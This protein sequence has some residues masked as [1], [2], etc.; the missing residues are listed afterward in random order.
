M[1]STRQS[2]PRLVLA[3]LWAAA[4]SV[5][6][7][8]A[9]PVSAKPPAETPDAANAFLD[10]FVG[11]WIGEG[12]A[13]GAP[14]GDALLC[15]RVLD[16]TFL[17][18]QDQAIG[19]SFKADTYMGYHVEDRRYELY[20]FNN[21]TALGS[22]LPV[23]VMTGHRDGDRLVMEERR[24]PQSLRYTFEFLDQDTF[25]LTKAF[26]TGH[27]DPFVIEIFRRQ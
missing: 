23:R 18:M 13:S 6:L 8:H 12:T 4:V 27:G 26:L 11:S 5:E 14:I 7:F 1:I 24:G 15:D 16:G 25:Q 21:N 22:S 9:A 10:R 17:F 2:R 19:G 20:T 3:L